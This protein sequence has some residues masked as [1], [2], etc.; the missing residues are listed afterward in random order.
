MADS[1]LHKVH[2]PI[3][4]IKLILYF[5]PFI[6]MPHKTNTKRIPE[7]KGTD[8]KIPAPASASKK[9]TSTKNRTS[10]ATKLPLQP[11]HPSTNTT[12]K[13]TPIKK[14]TSTAAKLPLQPVHP[15]ANIKT[16]SPAN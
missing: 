13:G 5:S 14:R 16:K 1:T 6:S 3:S 7:I 11:A 2:F 10:T 15:S 9:A 4:E 8:E 12:K